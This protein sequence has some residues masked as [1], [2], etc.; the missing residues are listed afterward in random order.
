MDTLLDKERIEFPCWIPVFIAIGILFGFNSSHINSWILSSSILILLATAYYCSNPFINLFL[1]GICCILVGIFSLQ[2]RISNIDS[3]IIPFQDKYIKIW[4]NIDNITPLEK[5]HRII[6]S[7]IFIPNLNK[8]DTPKK[9]RLSVRTKINNAKIGDRITLSAIVSKPM[10]PY[11]ENSYNFARDAYFKQIGAVGYSVSPLKLIKTDIKSWQ[12]K[13]NILRSNIQT[14]VN[15]HIGS[16]YGSIATALMLNE[17]NNIDKNVLK[18]LRATGLAHILSVSGMHLSLVAAIFFFS[19]RFMLNCSQPIALRLHCKKIAAFISLLGTFGYLLISGMEV[20]AI[21]SFIMSSM[22]TIAI[23][24]DRTSNPMRAV[25]FA[26]SIILV[27]S[28]ENIVHPS[29]QMSFAAVVALVS[30]FEIFSKLKFNFSDLSIMQ[31]TLLYLFSL[32]FASLV[33]GLATAPFALYHFGQ[34]ANYSILANLLAVPI[35]SFWLMPCVILSFLLYPLNLEFLP[36]YLMKYGIH[37]MLKISHYIAYL[38]HSVTSFMKITDISLLVISFGMIW[39]CIW[40]S[41]IRIIGIIIALT[42]ILIQYSTPRPDIFIDWPNKIIAVIDNKNQIIFLNKSISKFKQQ[43]LMSQ[44]GIKT[45]LNYPEGQS[46]QLKCNKNICL[47]HKNNY[48]VKFNLETMNIEI[49]DNINYYKK[50]IPKETTE[51]ITLE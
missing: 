45:S 20:A 49:N 47:L 36:L 32:S 12:G 18:D 14:R 3:P 17:Y 44:L 2:I 50:L 35:T 4:G 23:I 46:K 1:T 41:K 11:M 40:R 13:L 27:I 15:Q 30:C 19:S 34:S 33:A 7:N 9:I 16:Y 5:G 26:A 22:I 51:L 24:I 25:A 28:P 6:L 31:K 39:F 48:Q 43:L 29:F 37:L 42:G 10:R 21:R 8:N 38:P